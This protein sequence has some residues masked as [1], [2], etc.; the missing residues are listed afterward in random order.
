VSRSND[1]LTS[2]GAYG[3]V[4]FMHPSYSAMIPYSWARFN[5]KTGGCTR[6]VANPSAEGLAAEIEKAFDWKCDSVLDKA[7]AMIR[8]WNERVPQIIGGLK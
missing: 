8:Q 1:V 5:D 4:E 2:G 3:N 7:G 6:F